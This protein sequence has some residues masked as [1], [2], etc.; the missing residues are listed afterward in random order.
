MGSFLLDRCELVEALKDLIADRPST[1]GRHEVTDPEWELLAP[2]IPEPRAGPGKQGRPPKQPRQM[3]N[4]MLWVLRTGAPWRDMPT[5]YGKWK[6]VHN[7]LTIWRR[8][9]VFDRM[10]EGLQAK[11]NARGSIDWDLWC[12]DGTNIRAA[13]CAAGALKKGARRRSRRITR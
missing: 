1:P 5:R 6:T 8:E 11:L 4:G 3:L 7:R 10:V 12:V 13:R 2:F 9:R